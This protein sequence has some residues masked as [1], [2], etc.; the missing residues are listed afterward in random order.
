VALRDGNGSVEQ[1]RA[2]HEQRLSFLLFTDP[3][4]ESFRQPSQ[5]RTKLRRAGR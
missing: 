5:T 2:F 3:S 1:A 4:L